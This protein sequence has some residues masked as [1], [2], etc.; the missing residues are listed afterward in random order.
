M[1]GLYVIIGMTSYFITAI[2]LQ[3]ELCIPP[4][5]HL[6]YAVNTLWPVTL[7][8]SGLRCLYDAHPKWLLALLL[9]YVDYLPPRVQA[10]A[11]DIVAAML[12]EEYARTGW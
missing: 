5:G 11:V 12:R 7:Y 9:Q 4:L 10:R 2:R 8:V 1:G 6:C 3:R